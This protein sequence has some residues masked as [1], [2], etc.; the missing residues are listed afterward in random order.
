[1]VSLSDAQLQ[2]VMTA[3]RTIEPERRGVFLQRVGAMLRLRHRFTDHDVA[4]VCGL[5]VCGLQHMMRETA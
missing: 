2:T 5:A 1:M 3:A 4:D